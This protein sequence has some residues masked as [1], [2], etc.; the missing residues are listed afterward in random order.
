MYFRACF[1]YNKITQCGTGKCRQKEEEGE[2]KMGGT[3][4]KKKEKKGLNSYVV[5]FAVI[6]LMALLTWFVPGG[7]YELDEAGYAIAGTYRELPAN[8]QGLW[9]VIT[10]PIT[11]MVGNGAV[12]GAISISLYIMLFGSFLKMMEETGV[13][14][15]ALTSVAKKFQEKPYV[16]ITI[17]VFILS[18]L[19]TSQGAYEE[20]AI[21]VSL[22]LPI[23]LA[24]G[25]DTI[26][27][28][29]I[30][31]FGTQIGCAASA[32]NPFST[33]IAS[34]IAGI[35]FGDGIIP[36][37]ILFFVL[38]GTVAALISLYAKKVQ[39]NPE[40]SVQFY[41][42]KED[43]EAFANS[44]E[45]SGT[46]NNVKHMTG[47][48]IVFIMT[49]VIMLLALFPWTSINENFTFFTTIAEWINTTPIISTVIG[50]N[51]VA[52]G[53]WYF[54]ELTA[55]MMVMCLIAGFMAGY[56]LDRIINIIIKGAAE[57]VST[58]LIV[59]MARGIQVI[60]T[61]GNITSTILHATEVTL[62]SL[63]VVIFVI[64]AFVIYLI[65]ACFLPSSTGLAGATISVIV[66]LGTFAGVPPYVMIIIYNFALGIAKM[67]T[68]T[69]IAVM[70]CTQYAKIDYMSWV[71][72]VWK[73]LVVIFLVCLAFALGLTLM[74]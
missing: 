63:P 26:T 38:S 11:G 7:E 12:S 52:F 24:M 37:L 33:G 6:V 47:L 1:H 32:I 8:P 42:R 2:L 51:V 65:F 58:A 40:K 71:K 22:F 27:V 70:T 21:Y 34:D 57:L 54:T 3:Q 15:Y 10:A 67:F 17:L 29:M 31:V 68:P 16:L 39:A 20:C 23:F 19:G 61:S 56:D 50:S 74:G 46:S 69:S 64:L 73:P 35:S 53:D 43:L 41:R 59:P 55:L 13:I 66:P 9:D 30:S 5:I 14:G 72:A 28:V 62:G 36:R 45:N 48:L 60:M 18:F 44:E 4:K 49:F 25:M